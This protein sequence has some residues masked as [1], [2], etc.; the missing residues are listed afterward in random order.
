MRKSGISTLLLHPGTAP[1]W[2]LKRMKKLAEKVFI[3]LYEE[4]GSDL[5]LERL[6]NPIWFQC[7]SNTLAFDWNSSGTTTVLTGVLKS[8]LTEDYGIL[9]AGGKGKTALKTPL[10]I[11]EISKKFEFSEDKT[12][13]LK[14][15]SR[16]AAKIDNAVIQDSYNLYH[17]AMFISETG[18]WTIVQQGLN[19]EE[20]LSRRYHWHSKGVNNFID[21]YPDQIIGNIKHKRVL[22]MTSKEAEESRKTCIDLAKEKPRKIENLFNYLTSYSKNKILYYLDAQCPLKKVPVLHYKL[23]PKKMNWN[24]LKE[25]YEF[26]PSNYEEIISIKGIGPATIRGL[27]LISELIYGNYNDWKDPVK[28]T[29][30]LGGKDGV[31]YPVPL[32]RYDNTIQILKDA[33]ESAKIGEKEKLDAIKRL[34]RFATNIRIKVE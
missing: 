18:N 26:Q 8:V 20:K 34:K 11:E 12:R 14:Y 16:L 19:I 28:Y 21:D 30:C 15:S 7:L 6:S 4:F 17:H 10:D 5:I 31:P 27:A 13:S 23:I 3:I 33:V 25:T 2:L 32:K 9:V 1:H 24:A 29:F 22:N